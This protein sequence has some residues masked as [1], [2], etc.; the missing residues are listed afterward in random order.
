MRLTMEVSGNG[1]RA[2]RGAMPGAGQ[3]GFG[4]LTW[5]FVSY[6]HIFSHSLLFPSS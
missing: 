6:T 3:A 4:F 5:S 2:W 1:V